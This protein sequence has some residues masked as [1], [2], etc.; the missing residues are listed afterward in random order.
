MISARLSDN[1]SQ[2]KKKKKK[3]LIMWTVCTSK[4]I[5]IDL[6]EPAWK[7]ICEP[8]TN[9]CEFHLKIYVDRCELAEILC[10][11]VQAMV[12]IY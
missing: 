12:R 1:V 2:Q 11:P 9:F 10:E 6:C 3:K 8:K 5:F 4:K 7:F